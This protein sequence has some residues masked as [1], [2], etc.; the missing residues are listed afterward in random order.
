MFGFRLTNKSC[1]NSGER[2]GNQIFRK[3]FTLGLYVPWW[4]AACYV[5]T[6]QRLITKKGILNKT[7]VSLPL[8]YVQ[9]ASVHRAWYDVARV[10]ISTAGGNEGLS[11]MGELKP[12]AR[13]TV[14]RHDY[15]SRQAFGEP[16]SRTGI[17]DVTETLS[18][19]AQLRDSGALTDEE[20]AQQKARF[21]DQGPDFSVGAPADTPLRRRRKSDV[22]A[23]CDPEPWFQAGGAYTR[24]I[25]RDLNIRVASGVA[26]ADGGLAVVIKSV[27]EALAV[28]GSLPGEERQRLVTDVEAA[29]AAPDA[30]AAIEHALRDRPTLWEI[31]QRLV[32]PEQLWVL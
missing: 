15:G 5:V 8:K 21:S 23:G 6:D 29:K 22:C 24:Q 28:I 20:F 2:R 3:V 30:R 11:R 19:L 13:K 31:C 9:D 16:S 4:R 25:P 17:E 12:Q 7:D 14:C 32:P 18:R 27:G 26:V 10:D 1:C